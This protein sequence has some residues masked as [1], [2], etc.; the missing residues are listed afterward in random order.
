[1]SAR[2]PL[3]IVGAVMMFG[4]L[5][6]PTLYCYIHDNFFGVEINGPFYYW[7]FGN[8]FTWIEKK[9]DAGFTYT[10]TYVNFRPDIL[11]IICMFIIIIG[12]ILALALGCGTEHKAAAIG[13]TL[14]IVGMISFYVGVLLASPLTR[15]A[16]ITEAG[17]YF[18]PFIG[19]YICIV[20]SI[21]ALVGC[22]LSK[23]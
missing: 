6:L 23:Y 9:S 22:T 1:M 19:F 5:L 13:G 8:L 2:L 10:T 4:S 3:T 20:G 21:L 14:G 18:I 17:Y 16:D 12:G 7:I 11:G 15:L